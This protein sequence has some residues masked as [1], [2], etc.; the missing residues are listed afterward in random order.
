MQEYMDFFEQNR[1][2]CLI[3]VAL[4]VALVFNIFKSVTAKFK[5]VSVNELTQAVNKE[6]GLVIDIRSQDDFVKGHIT[7]SIHILPSDVKSGNLG[8]LENRKADPIIVVCRSGQAA[9]ATAGD[10]V[11]AGFE[12]VSVLANGI[13]AWN[14]ANLPLVRG[15]K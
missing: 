1:F 15:K 8:S 6:N 11:K 10:L 3:W 14:D 9:Q 13:S 2:I 4:L 7:D 5:S 12:Q